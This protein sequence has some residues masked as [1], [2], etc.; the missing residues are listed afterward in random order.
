MPRLSKSAGLQ[1]RE[2]LVSVAEKLFLK[3]GYENITV[4]QL[5]D[6]LDLAKGTFYYHFKSKENLLVAVSERL[7]INTHRKLEEAH[8]RSDKSP[9]WQLREMLSI[10]HD[11]FY[12]NRAIWKLVY[13]DRNISMHRKVAKAAGKR[14]TPLLADVLYEA[15]EARLIDTPHPKETAEV[16]INMFDLFSRQLCARASHERRVRI[17]ETLRFVLARVLGEKAIPEFQGTHTRLES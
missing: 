8:E 17:F 5:T 16:L 13:D 11:D 7:I 14:M 2:A 4:S 9:M 3:N 15:R 1:R 10:L 6:S 12:R